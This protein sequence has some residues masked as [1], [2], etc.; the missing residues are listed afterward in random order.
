MGRQYH[1]AS[2]GT[3]R[4]SPNPRGGTVGRTRKSL[5][6]TRPVP[7]DLQ[8]LR[9]RVQAASRV[10]L[11][12]DF[13]GTLVPFTNRPEDAVLTPEAERVLLQ[14]AA[15]PGTSVAVLSG[16]GLDDLK[17]RVGPQMIR[18]GNHGLEIEGA[19]LHFE[20]ADARALAPAVERFCSRMEEMLEGIPGA[21]VERKGPTATVH[22]RQAPPDLKEWIEATVHL[23]LGGYG[24]YLRI[25]AGWMVWEVLPRVRWDKGMALDLIVNHMGQ[26]EPLVV[27]IGDD[28]TDEDMFLARP[29]AISI[30][31]GGERKSSA[32]YSA[33]DPGEVLTV[34][35]AVLAARTRAA[36]PRLWPAAP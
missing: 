20:H 12:L 14:L 11:A 15:A 8:A 2:G 22:Y 24:M 16:R 25:R 33:K 23:A 36:T 5:T 35:D 3:G 26:P 4:I 29:D 6:L 27:C 32:R 28:L 30:R 17:A 1:E 13:D 21:W 31:V 19:G 10:L 18:A 34:L 9:A 7:V